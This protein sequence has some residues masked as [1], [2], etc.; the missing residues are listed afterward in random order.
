MS[1]IKVNKI[2]PRTACGTTTL[3]DSGDTFTIPSGVTITN[4]GTA[5]GFG[6]TGA[7]N[8]QTTVKTSGFTAVN[9]EGYF[10]DTNGGPIT[11]NLPA[12]SAGAVVG[13]KD[14]RNTFDTSPCT[15]N[16]NGSDKAGGSTDD[17][18]LGA[19]G[20]A[21]TLVFIDSTRGWLVTDSGLQSDAP[22]SLYVTATGGT[23]ATVGDFKVHQFT[24]PGTFCVS[25]KGNS[26]GSNQVDYMVVA[27]GGAGGHYSGIGGGGAGGMRIGSISDTSP[28]IP[29]RAPGFSVCAQAYPVTVGGGGASTNYPTHN[30]TRAPNGSPS[31]ALGFTAAGGGGGARGSGSPVPASGAQTG[32]SGG[33]GAYGANSGAAGNTP[34]VSP[35]QGNPGGTGYPGS[36]NPDGGGGG[37]GAGAAGG[38]GGCSVGGT[39]GAGINVAPVF[40][41]APQPFYIANQSG[42][43]GNTAC[44]QF[45]GG[46]GGSVYSG[47]PAAGG[48]GGGANGA[49]NSEGNGKSGTTNSG[50]GGAGTQSLPSTSGAGG[51]GIVLIRYKFQ[52]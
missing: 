33:G 29:I 25:C 42:S 10:V 7:V 52:N 43:A 14:Y 12:G 4:N 45:A 23:I 46:S 6:A 24:G 27:G 8:W 35:P 26:G 32:G 50:G 34:S 22:Q 39:G 18:I 36:G 3:G 31:S 16:L 20:I 44:G 1:E 47:S 49:V 40:G 38:T 30:P 17:V 51:S 48:I 19:E 11:V 15:L 5:N 41:S 2:S 9:G 13:F 21:V 28:T 37:G